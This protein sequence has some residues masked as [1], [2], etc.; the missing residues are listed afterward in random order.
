MV[1]RRNR[2][3]GEAGAEQEKLRRLALGLVEVRLAE[4]SAEVRCDELG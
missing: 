1:G 4:A 3:L 2:T